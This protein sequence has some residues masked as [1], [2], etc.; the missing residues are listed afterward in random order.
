MT[1][2]DMGSTGGDARAGAVVLAMRDIGKSFP[3]VRALDGVS[4]QVHEAEV[5]ALLGENGAGKSTLMNVLAGG[6][7]AYDGSIEVR[8]RPAAIYQPADAHALGIE[9]IHQ[10]LNLVP[11]LSIA[12][13]IFLGRELR[14]AR[15]TLDRPTMHRRSR[16]LL[17]RL[18]LAL[19]PKRLIRRCKLAEQQ[20]IEVA[21]A[22]SLGVRILVMDEPTSALADAEVERLFDVIRGLVA[23]G[24][25]VIYISHRLEELAR[26][27]TT[28]SVL[29]DGRLVDTRQMTRSS[30][31]ELIALMVGRP[32]G[33]LFPRPE[34]PPSQ[35]IRLSVRGLHA[36]GDAR[37]G[38]TALRAVDLEVCEGEI[39]GLAG[40]M[41]A[42]RSEL[43]Q[44]IYGVVPGGVTAGQIAIAGRR[45]APRSPAYAIDRGIAMVAEDRKAQSLVLGNT[46]RFNAS[47]A[48]L[49]RF[50]HW[51]GVSTKEERAAVGEVITD[52]RVK[53]PSLA[54]D[55]NNLSGGNQQK[56]VLGRCLLT[57]PQVLLM[58]EPTRGIDVG[59]KAEIYQL[60]SDLA[61]RGTGIVMASSELPE[62]LAMCDRIV[63]LCEGR[64]TGNFDRTEATQERILDAAMARQVVLDEV[65]AP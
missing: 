37:A 46:V 54:T 60:M 5:H 33:D 9:M 52:L 50:T 14:T 1:A 59:A 62:L 2:P 15:G 55:V 63:V 49:D 17:A 36:D 20:L 53:T 44:A 57:R 21:K 32:M 35:Q 12:D 29:R 41:G 51:T 11:D 34:D 18:G 48:S 43:L 4:V 10:E 27:A 42:G 40:L 19:D 8:G 39:V 28:V 61:G 3:G 64:V 25:A 38:R 7:T 16:E 65:A 23:D 58:D 6:F 45:Y 13:N 47:L 22:L 26:I 31:T 56:V 24:V 30:R